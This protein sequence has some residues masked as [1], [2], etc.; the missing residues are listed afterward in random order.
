LEQVEPP[1]SESKVPADGAVQEPPSCLLR[2]VQEGSQEAWDRLARLCAPLVY[3]WCRRAGLEPAEAADAGQQ[4]FRTAALRVGDFHRG[5][6]G[7]FRAWLRAI[8]RAAIYDHLC[9]WQ[10]EELSA[11]SPA[12]THVQPGFLPDAKDAGPEED[13]EDAALLYRR[14]AELVRDGC[15][16]GDWRAF[17]AVDAEG[18]LPAEAAEALGMPPPAVHLARARVRHRLRGEFGSVLDP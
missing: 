10:G 2:Q 7:P 16:E 13:R 4:A 5:R 3:A 15:A 1:V 8:T 6:D 9:R 11:G 12:E 18:R 17:W 14:A